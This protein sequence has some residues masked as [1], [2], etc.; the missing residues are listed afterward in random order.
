MPHRPE[1]QLSLEIHVMW[2]FKFPSL[3]QYIPLVLLTQV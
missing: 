3:S 1:I 2:L